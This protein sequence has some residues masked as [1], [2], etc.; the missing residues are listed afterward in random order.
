LSSPSAFRDAYGNLLDGD[1]NGLAGGHFTASFRVDRAAGPVPA[2]VEAMLP[3]GSLVY[4]SSAA[5]SD[6]SGG[7]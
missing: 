1:D 7:R 2:P 6:W 3:P 5:R 4:S